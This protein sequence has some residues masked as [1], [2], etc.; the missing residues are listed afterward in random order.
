M[1]RTAI[2]FAALL[3]L[4]FTLVALTRSARSNPKYRWVRAVDTGVKTWPRW[5]VP[6]N[7]NDGTLRMIADNATWTSAD[8]INWSMEPHNASKAV[9]PGTSQIFFKGH[10]WLMGG[11]NNWSQFTNEIWSSPDGTQWTQVAEQTPWS[12]RRNAML[13]EFNNNLWLLGGAKS[14]GTPEV[15][16][17]RSLRD[18]WQSADGVRW[19]R[20][21]D[22][23][24]AG[25]EKAL[26]FQS[27]IWVLG[28]GG[29]WRSNDG[30][31]W[32]QTANGKPFI[33]RGS[34]G[35]TVYDGRMWLFGG[36]GRDKTLNDVWSSVDGVTW[37]LETDHAPWFPRGAGR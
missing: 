1:K 11:M 17:A 37:Q 7:A 32:H 24:P 10:F 30:V 8:G 19:I 28:R 5:V 4:S 33:N 31:S 29:A 34:F 2:F 15:M 22:N 13:V 25:G 21:S 36:V 26:V 9:R 23:L 18:V 12:A 27:H 3:T 20:I 6:L 35:A 16:S 14:N